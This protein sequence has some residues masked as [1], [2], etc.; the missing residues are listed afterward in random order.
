MLHH[1]T[2]RAGLAA[3]LL[4][5]MLALAACAPEHVAPPTE[6]TELLPPMF[7]GIPGAQE[8]PVGLPER[9]AEDTARHWTRCGDRFAARTF[10]ADGAP[11]GWLVA[12]DVSFQTVESPVDSATRQLGVSWQAGVNLISGSYRQYFEESVIGTDIDGR[13]IEQAG[14]GPAMPFTA[15]LPHWTVQDMGE[16]YYVEFRPA[17]TD[18]GQWE[19]RYQPADCAELPPGLMTG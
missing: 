11:E 6:P 3:A 10:R 13:R 16:G 5:P 17:A 4:A 7:A 18:T 8:L 15:P 9:L 12:E 1:A 2:A 19:A 14:W